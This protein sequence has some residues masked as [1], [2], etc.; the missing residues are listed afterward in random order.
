V[1][2]FRIEDDEHVAAAFPVVEEDGEDAPD[3]A[4]DAV[5]DAAE[6]SGGEA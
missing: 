4:P 6:D 2:L 5:P 1:T 3:G